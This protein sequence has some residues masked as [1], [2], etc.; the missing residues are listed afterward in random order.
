M[1]IGDLEAERN[2]VLC[3]GVPLEVCSEVARLVGPHAVVVAAADTHAARELLAHDRDDTDAGAG[4]AEG[5]GDL[6]RARTSRTNA[7][8]AAG[9]HAVGDWA[10]GGPPSRRDVAE[11]PEAVGQPDTVGRPAR[12]FTRGP[13]QV[14]LATREVTFR[15]RRVHL[16]IREFDLLAA[17]ASETD[18]VWSFAEL[19][20]N[21]WRTG[22]LGDSDVVVSTVKRLRR[23]LLAADGL[24]VASV[25]GIGYRLKIA[26]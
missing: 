9:S 10:A 19:T 20:A 8:Q 1:S 12:T 17:L 3:I 6:V 7:G 18:R 11:R 25:R 2:Y 15:G 4:A 21:V 5:L 22:Y 14:N 13:L 23:R 26:S 16:S 24:E